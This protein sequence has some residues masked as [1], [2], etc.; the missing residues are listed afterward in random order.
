MTKG[1]FYNAFE[2]KENFLLETIASFDKSN[3]ERIISVLAPE[4]GVKAIDQLIEF[5]SYMVKAQPRVNFMG[6]MVNNMIAAALGFIVIAQVLDRATRSG[7]LIFQVTV[8][9]L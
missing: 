5:Y 9:Y 7:R 6:C 8:Y 3:T 1:A 2:S 4:K